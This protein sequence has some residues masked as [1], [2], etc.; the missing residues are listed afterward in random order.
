MIIVENTD[1]E[2]I[3]TRTQVRKMEDAIRLFVNLT[4]SAMTARVI[5]NG[6]T[7]CKWRR[8]VEVQNEAMLAELIEGIR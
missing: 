5:I 7:L 1:E 3:V 2:G 8:P 6:F 4:A